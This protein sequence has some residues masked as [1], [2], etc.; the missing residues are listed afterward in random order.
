[1]PRY[2]FTVLVIFGASL[3]LVFADSHTL[4]NGPNALQSFYV[5]SHVVSDAA[6]FWYDYVLEVRPANAGTLIREIRVAPLNSYC[7][8]PVTVKA[9][10]RVF[11]GARVESVAKIPLCSFKKSD[12]AAAIKAA[13]PSALASINDA[14]SF[15]IVAKCGKANRVLELPF[16]DS[17]D[18]ALL[19]RTSPSV[20]TLWSLASDIRESAF[21]KG[22]SFYDVSD[23]QNAAFQELGSKVVSAIKSGM[24]DRG[25]ARHG[26]LSS[27]L[28]DYFG[29][30]SLQEEVDPGM[31]E[32]VDGP[33]LPFAKYT[34]PVFPP[35]ARQARIQGEV[36]LRI[37]L[38]ASTGKVKDVEV[39]SG[40][41]ILADPA[42]HSAFEWEFQPNK[43]FQESV[44]VGVKFELKCPSR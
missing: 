8:K 33:S 22:F 35:L 29:P 19:K 2:L 15:T 13:K 12:I 6:P 41:P 5:V 32:L 34:L 10:E 38:D 25:F 26:P 28:D 23:S 39:T 37:A 43:I 16:E 20:A 44:N 4:A 36:Y 42:V 30:I 40:H 17:V 1:M 24:Y 9:A 3:S 18:F 11:S 21:G 27:V 7:S 31:V 14:V